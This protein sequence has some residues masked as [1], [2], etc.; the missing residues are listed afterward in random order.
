MPNEFYSSECASKPEPSEDD[1][2]CL[3]NSNGELVESRRRWRPRFR[4]PVSYSDAF[5]QL[6]KANELVESKQLCYEINEQERK[7]IQSQI[8][9]R[10]ANIIKLTR[11]VQLITHCPH[12]DIASEPSFSV[13]RLRCKHCRAWL[14]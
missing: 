13:F 12:T 4:Y 2:E 8:D 11:E 10:V 7:V 3:S 1:F 9:R 6:Q 14:E 5:K